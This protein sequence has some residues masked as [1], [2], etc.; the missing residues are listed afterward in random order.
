MNYRHIAVIIVLSAIVFANALPGNFVWDDEIQIIKNFRIRT[1]DNLPSAFTTAFW[2]FLG[3]EAENQ[4]NFYRPVQTVTYM[5]AYWIGGLSPTPYHVFSL[6]YH[7]AASVFVYLI[8]LELMLEPA[9]ALA[10][11]A[12]F[13]VHPIHTE[14]VAWI[15][16]IPD[17]ACGAFYFGAVWCFLRHL[18]ER[19]PSWLFGSCAMFFAALLSKE[20]AV[21]L[22]F[23]LLLIIFFSPLQRGR[24]APGGRGSFATVAPFFGVLAFYLIL[25]V[26]ALGLL[27]TSHLQVQAPWLDW[28]SLA[29]R[30]LG[31]YIR[32]AIVPYPLNAFHLV[33]LKLEY[34]LL[35]TSLAL[36]VILLIAGLLWC[37]RHRL[38]HGIF[39]FATFV[40]ML[41]PVFYFKGLSNTFFA[42]RY[43]YIPSFAMIMLVFTTASEFK[44]PRLNWI[45]GVIA[46]VFAL[47]AAYRNEAW[48]TS[49][50]LYETTL[51]VQPEVAHMRINL[52]DI[53]LKRNEDEAA[54]KLLAS[55]EQ[56][57]QSDTYVRYPYE[58]YRTYVGLGAIEARATR[59]P[60]ARE[61]LKKA[62]E[63]NPNGD[64]GYLYLGGVFMEADGDY[65]QAIANFQKAVQLGPLN[66]VARDYLGI[67]MLNQ[68]KKAEAIQYFE[69]ALKIN[70]NYE[71]AR[72]HLNIALR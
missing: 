1:L 66:E 50:T 23:V 10:I 70:P 32:Y 24:A 57:M 12:L 41:M 44:I 2:S 17:V 9:M 58:L 28:I 36:A 40:L 16:G 35:S 39:W 11:A 38:P 53:H 45:A 20:M 56:Y 42:E 48:A 7:T 69:E 47:T 21:T 25:R 14:A 18:R 37:F 33:P 43:L 68:K 46:V 30:V 65:P 64:W 13:A 6:L 27:A 59:Y 67:A 63:V 19:H 72:Q 60:Q 62:I 8:A 31:D 29:V 15:A 52:A 61:H 22:P 3:N 26:L 55:A 71:E 5:L 49:E 51:T 4:T 54:R 34:R